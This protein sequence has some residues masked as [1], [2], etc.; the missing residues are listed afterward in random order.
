MVMR[1][2]GAAAA[3]AVV[4]AL[5]AVACNA[6][7]GNA[8]PVLAYDAP[9]APS[10]GD[11][12]A[13]RDPSVKRDAGADSGA[14]SDANSPV[15][16]ATDQDSPTAVAVDRET[17]GYVYWVLGG[18]AKLI[19]R[20]PKSRPEAAI[21]T[22]FKSDDAYNERPTEVAVDDADLFWITQNDHGSTVYWGDKDG[23]FPHRF[24]HDGIATALALDG[25]A[26]YWTTEAPA[27]IRLWPTVGG[28][29]SAGVLRWDLVPP[30]GGDPRRPREI[31]VEPGASGRIFWMESNARDQAM[32]RMSKEGTAATPLYSAP[33]GASD[34]SML[35]VLALTATD[36]YFTDIRGD[37]I[38]RTNKDGQCP[39]RPACPEVVV[40]ATHVAYPI[41]LTLDGDKLYWA[42]REDGRIARCNLDG[43][44]VTTLAFAKDTPYRMAIDDT[45]IYF[46]VRSALSHGSVW[47][48][49]K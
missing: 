3:G 43:S 41:Q 16:I 36:I 1:S 39:G 30:P 13:K 14:D 46:T 7:V 48:V 2:I 9:D 44:Q 35:P 15:A 49:A 19:V 21:E 8:D 24:D 20:K 26:I 27:S 33:N 5:G 38:L 6:L 12:G 18:D 4:F 25:T 31:A 23:A 17:A 10:G 29:G 11:T 22:V 40:D 47:K 28:G 37:R 34:T 32:H 42:N 45:A